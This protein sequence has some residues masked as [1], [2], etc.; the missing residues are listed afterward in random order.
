MHAAVGHVQPAKFLRTMRQPVFSARTHAHARL[1]IGAHAE[2]GD[3]HGDKVAFGVVRIFQFHQ[4]KIAGMPEWIQPEAEPAAQA[5]LALAV[6]Q[7]VPADDAGLL[8]ALRFPAVSGNPFDPR[9]GIAGL[10]EINRVF[11]LQVQT[12]GI[13]R[14]GHDFLVKLADHHERLARALLDDFTAGFE[15]QGDGVNSAGQPAGGNPSRQ[16][17][18]ARCEYGLH[19]GDFRGTEPIRSGAADFIF[20]C[21]LLAGQSGRQNDVKLYFFLVRVIQLIPQ[22]I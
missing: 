4:V 3:H 5:V 12:F 10:G 13:I 19:P 17:F 7:S 9:A 22:R 11:Q 21:R 1:G 16:T 8:N 2:L 18:R 20:Q 14:T 6:S 15:R